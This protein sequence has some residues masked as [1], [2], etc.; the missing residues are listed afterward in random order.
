MLLELILK[1]LAFWGM[2]FGV[3]EFKFWFEDLCNKRDNFNNK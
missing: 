1:I 3:V 2:V